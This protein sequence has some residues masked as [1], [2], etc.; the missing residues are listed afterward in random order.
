LASSYGRRVIDLD[1]G[2]RT[3]RLDLEPLTADHAAELA[4]VLDDAALHEFIGGAPLPAL[5]L[6]QRYARLA[7]RRSPDGHQLWGNWV[8]RVRETGIAVGT[9]QVTMPAGGAAAGPAE[10]AWV[11]GRQAQGRG[12]AKEAAR[13]LVALLREAGWTVAAHI[14]PA[15]LASQRVARAAGLSPTQEVQ[16][17][18]VRWVTSAATR[19][20]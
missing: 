5:A 20:P 14:H 2:W 4:P 19:S 15:H 10:V 17:G 8:M 11:V 16:D 6:A 13:G 3:E 18:E 9:M 1:Q 12:Y 7:A